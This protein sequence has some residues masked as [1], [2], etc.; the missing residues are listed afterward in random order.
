MKIE[1][2]SRPLPGNVTNTL[3]QL[4]LDDNVIREQITSIGTEDV[5]T[6]AD[7]VRF[8]AAAAVAALGLTPR[9]Q[10][11]PPRGRRHFSGGSDS[12]SF[13]AAPKRAKEQ[14]G[15]PVKAK[16]VVEDEGPDFNEATAH[17]DVVAAAYDAMQ[18]SA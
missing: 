18:E 15:R 8:D 4:V 9:S 12:G 2:R 11:T 5:Y 13:H 16:N 10:I 3:F 7:K 6:A 17:A 14:G 1:I